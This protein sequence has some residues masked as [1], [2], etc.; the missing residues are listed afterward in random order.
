MILA[1]KNQ[2]RSNK[3]N[4]NPLKCNISKKRERNNFR[5]IHNWSKLMK[6]VPSYNNKKLIINNNQLVTI[7][8]KIDKQCGNVYI[9]F[10][11]IKNGFKETSHLSLH[12]LYNKRNTKNIC[13][14]WPRNKT[15]KRS[16]TNGSNVHYKID[17]NKE[18]PI[19]IPFFVRNKQWTYK[20][21][22]IPIEHK[23]LIDWSIDKL[24]FFSKNVIR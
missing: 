5:Q 22:L 7:K 11:W 13:T 12:Y 4:L 6:L 2:T 8:T 21:D 10:K 19:Y 3:N 16:M 17:T 23:E 1:T 20:N 14:C 15:R 9:F 24:N 18:H